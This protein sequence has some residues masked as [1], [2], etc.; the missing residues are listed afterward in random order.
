MKPR[1]NTNGGYGGRYI[2]WIGKHNC[3]YDSI[4]GGVTNSVVGFC[5]LNRE[6]R[7]Q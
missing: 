7:S 3:F 1:E 4:Y 6:I 5:V 2:V